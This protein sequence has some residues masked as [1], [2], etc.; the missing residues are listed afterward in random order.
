MKDDGYYYDEEAWKYSFDLHSR[1]RLLDLEFKTEYVDRQETWKD[2]EALR[3]EFRV[4]RYFS[5]L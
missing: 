1:F 5:I 3:L 4:I 2:R